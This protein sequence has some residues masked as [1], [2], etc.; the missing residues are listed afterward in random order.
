MLSQLGGEAGVKNPQ[1]EKTKKY[2][3]IAAIGMIAV[4]SRLPAVSPILHWY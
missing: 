4:T 1:M 3:R 2:F